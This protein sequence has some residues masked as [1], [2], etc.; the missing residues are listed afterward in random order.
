MFNSLYASVTT[1]LQY[2]RVLNN[3]LTY[4]FDILFIIYVNIKTY[5]LNIYKYIE[6]NWTAGNMSMH[7][8]YIIWN[9]TKQL[10]KII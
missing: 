10:L 6:K 4:A 2:L 8:Y 9:L 5:F 7:Y 1:M 3:Y